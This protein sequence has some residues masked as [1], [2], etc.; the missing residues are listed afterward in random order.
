MAQVIL[1]N[2][3]RQRAA[4][5]GVDLKD[6]DRTVRFPDKITKNKHVKSFGSYQVVV[7]IKRQGNNWITISVWKEAALKKP[8]RKQY[9]LEK[10]IGHCLKLI[11]QKTRLP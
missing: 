11:S 5:R 9:F 1:T 4:E 6:L 8:V 7:P 10:L 2:H 3:V